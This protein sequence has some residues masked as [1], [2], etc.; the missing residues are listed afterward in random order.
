MRFLA[1][2]Y[3]TVQDACGDL[4]FFKV[5]ADRVGK[6][7]NNDNW[8]NTVNHFGDM[9]GQLVSTQFA[10]LGTG[11]YDANN[12]FALVT[13]DSSIGDG[14]DWKLLTPLADITK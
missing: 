7:L 6:Y 1:E 14:G 2:I 13:F 9:G 12:G 3:I 5:I 8:T 11:K 4:T 10:S